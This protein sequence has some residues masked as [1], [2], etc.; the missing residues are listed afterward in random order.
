VLDAHDRL[1]CYGKL[2]SMRRLV[3]PSTR[4][5][6]IPE[7]GELSAGELSASTDG[8]STGFSREEE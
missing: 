5:T 3:P 2:S 1:L 8:D 6:R 4:R 7:A